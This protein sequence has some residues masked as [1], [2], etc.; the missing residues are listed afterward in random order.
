ML[1]LMRRLI[2]IGVRPYF[3]NGW[4]AFDA[5]ITALSIAGVLIGAAGLVA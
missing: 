2:A 5:F 4:N 3:R 1:V